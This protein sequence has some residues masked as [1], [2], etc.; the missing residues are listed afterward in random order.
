MKMQV[1]TYCYVLSCVYVAFGQ[2]TWH[3]LST[4][5]Y[6]IQNGSTVNHQAAVDSCASLNATLARVKTTQ[7]QQFL[8]SIITGTKNYYIGLNRINLGKTGF[9]WNDGTNVTSGEAQWNVDEPNNLG[10][11]EACVQMR[12]VNDNNHGWNDVPCNTPCNYIC[13]RHKD[14]T[15]NGSSV[16]FVYSSKSH[17]VLEIVYRMCLSAA[18]YKVEASA[19]MLDESLPHRFNVIPIDIRSYSFLARLERIDLNSGWSTS[20]INISWIAYFNTPVHIY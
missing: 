13:E 18:P 19:R 9:Q 4:S 11:N 6:Y 5:E 7:V 8:V 17:T 1:F 3:K 10:N 15:I 2:I 16:Q 20:E 12:G 14:I